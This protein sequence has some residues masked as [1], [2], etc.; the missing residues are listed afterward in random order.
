MSKLTHCLFVVTISGML[1][2]QN[3]SAAEL[4]AKATGPKWLYA[5]TTGTFGGAGSSKGG[6]VT[7][8]W[9]VTSEPKNLPPIE[10][11]NTLTA[12]FTPTAW[13]NY[14]LTLT[15]TNASGESKKAVWDFGVLNNPNHD[16]SPVFEG[17]NK[18]VYKEAPNIL[19]DK[20]KLYLH[21]FNPPDWKPTDKRGVVLLFHGGGW[22]NGSP[23]RYVKDAEYWA[24]RGLVAITGQYRLGKRE[25]TKVDD[26]VA[27]A[28]SAARYL[29]EHAA[30]LGIDPEKIAVGGES[31][32]AHISA[33]TA[34]L[35]AFNDPQDNRSVS[36]VP[37]ALLL[38]FPFSLICDR[39]SKNGDLSP[40]HFVGKDTPPTFIVAGAR[41]RIA[42]AEHCIE[43]GEKMQ[44]SEHP[45]KLVIY[46]RAYHPSGGQN[47]NTPG[48]D[49]DLIRQTDLFLTSLGF[50]QGAPTVPL[51]SD[52]D[53]A[54]LHM[55]PKDFVPPAK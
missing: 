4:V 22:G 15:V 50:L 35:P 18:I 12:T 8:Q 44:G 47:F 28:K 39:T 32:G 20:V 24:S 10:G 21:V 45:F 26:C 23:D 53:I 14:K 25:G 17:A 36:C 30:E 33:A 54:K 41:D 46:S 11:A 5:F 52:E 7:Y 42:P 2:N 37:N 31:A 19:G 16:T 48:L 55:D 27:D 1:W 13:W 9:T 3:S 38:H 51:M 43:W 49:N 34:T 40:L 29:R 6:G